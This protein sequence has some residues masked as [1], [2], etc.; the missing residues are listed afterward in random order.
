MEK[1]RR[2]SFELHSERVAEQGIRS[3]VSK[4]T[5]E[6]NSNS[7]QRTFDFGQPLQ[8]SFDWN[9]TEKETIQ[10]ENNSNEKIVIEEESEDDEFI[11]DEEFSKM[12]A[13]HDDDRKDGP[14]TGV[15]QTVNPQKVMSRHHVRKERKRRPVSSHTSHLQPIKITN[16][17]A[18]TRDR[19]LRNSTANPTRQRYQSESPNT[20]ADGQTVQS[21][22]SHSNI[23]GGSYFSN[24]AGQVLRP[25]FLPPHMN[26]GSQHQDEM[27]SQLLVKQDVMIGKLDTIVHL[28]MKIVEQKKDDSSRARDAPQVRI[29]SQGPGFRGS[30][31]NRELNIEDDEFESYEGMGDEP[32]QY[33]LPS[34]K[35]NPYNTYS[36]RFLKMLPLHSSSQT[37]K[38]FSIN[39]EELT[40]DTN[41]NSNKRSA[42]P[43]RGQSSTHSDQV[44]IETPSRNEYESRETKE[45]M[46]RYLEGQPEHIYSQT[47]LKELQARGGKTSKMPQSSGYRSNMLQSND[48]QSN[49]TMDMEITKVPRESV[50]PSTPT[51]T[52]YP[53]FID[54]QRSRSK[55]ANGLASDIS[56]DVTSD[57]PPM[58]NR[59]ADT[60]FTEVP[61]HGYTEQGKTEMSDRTV[62]ET[63]SPSF[64]S[65]SASAFHSFHRTSPAN[66]GKFT[67][68]ARNLSN[69]TTPQSVAKFYETEHSPS[70]SS[71]TCGPRGSFDASEGDSETSDSDKELS[72]GSVFS[73]RNDNNKENSSKFMVEEASSSSA[74]DIVKV[75]EVGSVTR[76]LNNGFETSSRRFGNLSEES[77]RF[78]ICNPDKTGKRVLSPTEA[79]VEE[80]MVSRNSQIT[81][82]YLISGGPQESHSAINHTSGTCHVV[83]T[84]TNGITHA[85]EQ[86]YHC[87]VNNDECMENDIYEDPSPAQVYYPTN[88]QSQHENGPVPPIPPQIIAKFYTESRNCMAFI[89]KLMDHYFTKEELKTCRVKGGVR[90]Y[91]GN[92][93]ET[94][95]LCKERMRLILK[96]AANHF[97][98]EYLH[99]VRTN[100]LRN[101]INQKC[102]KTVVKGNRYSDG[103]Y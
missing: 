23:N 71:T 81:V 66:D 39:R 28:L 19:F 47:V 22:R 9:S 68:V 85:D 67:E 93:T 26:G 65:R 69:E 64:S 77:E 88:A 92:S 70:K 57:T 59:S 80:N 16:C 54:L 13:N 94:R 99:L 27:I 98:E 33:F 21:P 4:G 101:S 36:K 25:V 20:G 76:A 86:G 37:N 89:Y 12:V 1:R 100:E 18:E 34:E 11:S 73:Q 102:R 91:R 41:N 3:S 29:Q 40:T 31:R 44:T 30:G 10:R 90:K 24:T 35:T 32:F 15:L 48:G 45:H 8:N 52:R 14:G 63:R 43:E 97:P 103:Q 83:V 7:H 50:H 84:S 60:H 17:S 87:P 74:H 38:D 79:S 78:W 58:M 5:T 61:Y 96:L 95:S 82:P 53:P 62:V 56:L 55:M 42:L 2:T 49:E 51:G 75:T 6:K 72:D 46:V